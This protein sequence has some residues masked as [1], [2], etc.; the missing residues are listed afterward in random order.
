MMLMEKWQVELLERVA[1]IEE[2][3]NF[4]KTN[5]AL[6]P[7]SPQ[8]ASDIKDIRERLDDMD[9]V[10][11]KLNV[12]LAYAGGVL[13]AVGSVLPYLIPWIVDRLG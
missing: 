10:M 2:N 12:R 5:L 13:V 9:D 6:L 8:C 1:R 3:Q 7:Q 11:T 4:I